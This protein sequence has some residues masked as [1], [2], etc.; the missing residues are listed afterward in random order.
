[1]HAQYYEQHG[2]DSASTEF[3]SAFDTAMTDPIN[4]EK[5]Y[6]VCPK[7]DKRTKSGEEQFEQL[8]KNNP[9]KKILP[10]SDYSKIRACI[11]KVATSPGLV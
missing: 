8:I 2:K 7:I 6:L 4:F 5:L 1:M 11:S 10:E 3:G 9:Q